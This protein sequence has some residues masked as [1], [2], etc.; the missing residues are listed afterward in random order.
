MLLIQYSGAYPWQRTNMVLVTMGDDQC[1][2]LITPLGQEGG[3]WQDFLHSQISLTA[4]A[5]YVL[6]Y[7]EGFL[8]HP[9]HE[10]GEQQSASKTQYLTA[11]ISGL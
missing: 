6:Q 1:F 7:S 8:A 9:D 5:S 11:H 2:N 3:V 10:A 4:Q